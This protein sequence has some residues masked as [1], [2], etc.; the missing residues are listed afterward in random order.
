MNLRFYVRK[1]LKRAPIG[2]DD[3]MSVVGC[4]LVCA[5]GA[6]QVVGGCFQQ[7]RLHL[8]SPCSTFNLRYLDLGTVVGGLGSH[9]PISDTGKPVIDR[10]TKVALQVSFLVLRIFES[11][12]RLFLI[13][14]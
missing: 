3:Y 1:T 7:N 5:M 9:T 11:R 6:N 4:I 8:R 10:R 13:H 14:P 2:I 12:L